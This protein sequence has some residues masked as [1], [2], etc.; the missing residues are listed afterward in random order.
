MSNVT[1][2]TALNVAICAHAQWPNYH[3][4]GTPRTKDGKPDL[5]APAPRLNGKPGSLRTLANR[6]LTRGFAEG[7]G[8]K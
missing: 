1:L 3:E 6:A 7:V 8:V 4:A 5:S 2:V